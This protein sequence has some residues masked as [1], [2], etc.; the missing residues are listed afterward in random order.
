VTAPAWGSAFGDI[1]IEGD[2]SQ[3][4]VGNYVNRDL[5]QNS[6]TFVR[7]QP[8]M[9][10]GAQEIADRV[11]CYVPAGNHDLIVKALEIDRAV[12]L[13]GPPGCGRETTAIAAIHQLHPGI[14]I[15]RFS[16][17]DDDAEEIYAKGA[18]GY[19]IHAADG[20]LARLGRCIEAVRA[21]GGY[22]AVIASA[23]KDP[24]RFPVSLP[25]IVVEPA[26]PVHVYQRRAT[27]RGLTEWRQWEDAP[28]LLKGALPDDA[29]R[30]TELIEQ[31]DRRAGDITTRR[32]EV[33]R[34]Y[35]GWEDELRGWFT[36]HREPHERAL[37]ISA[38]ALAPAAEDTN[39]YTLASS[40]ARRFEITMNG[41][42]L[43]WCPVTSLH[44]LLEAE[45]QDDRIVFRRYNFAASTLRH[46]LADYPLA[47]TDL[48]SWL[49]ALPTDE[50]VPHELRN[51][52]AETFADLA[53]EHGA[54]DLV[55]E[56]SRQWGA[57]GLADLA[58][59]ALSRTC[60]HA[61]IG[62]PVR[63][64]LYDWSRVG[65][66][67]QTLKLVIAR[68]CE[69]LGQTYPSI[70]LT[71]LKHLATRG[72]RQVI[73]EVLVAALALAE[74]GHPAEVLRATHA[75]CAETNIENL[76][77]QA[78]Q[79]RR[80]AGAMLFLELAR[81]VSESGLPVILDG[82]RTTNHVP[83][84]RAALDAR[85]AAPGARDEAFEEVTWRWLDAAHDHADVRQQI[86]WTFVGAASPSGAEVGPAYGLRTA[87]QGP[88][89]AKIMIDVARQWAMD[90]R[91]DPIRKE[92]KE[93]IVIPL[94]SPLW[95]KLLKILYIRLRTL[96]KT[97]RER[98]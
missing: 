48:L 44:D 12:V 95:L 98:Y 42:G 79:R 35:Q 52:L 22:L 81:P 61:R 92:I 90:D 58:F 78:R 66:T 50:A 85:T 15:R 89:R 73:R 40:L 27:L 86:L 14:L 47:R 65:R 20:G 7:R 87:R 23:E 64:A 19:L 94:T 16:L 39:V 34:A 37:L 25:S 97:V 21:A 55:I 67:P 6:Y 91:A 17:E 36:R 63:R 8:S 88:T 31:I 51:P 62:R 30:L 33:N 49:S 96:L 1:D 68:T 28:T 41:A 24:A 4:A 32:E 70:A 76:S 10:L 54:A 2:H 5:V 93:D 45:R 69:P 80:R 38:A 82:D 84:W 56:T 77:D 13:V 53:A 11:H 60:L 83:G 59:I 71:R 72:N 43:A 9:Y 3:N 75:W 74:Q 29:R 46:A 18:C 26:H 57:D